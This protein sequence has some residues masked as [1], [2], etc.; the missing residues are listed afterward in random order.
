[1]EIVLGLVIGILYGCIGN[2]IL[3]KRKPVRL[4]KTILIIYFWPIYLIQDFKKILKTEI[5]I[6]Y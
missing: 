2:I 1:M 6:D 3:R 4:Y 5:E